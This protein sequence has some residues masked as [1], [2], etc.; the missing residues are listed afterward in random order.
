[1]DIINRIH[2]RRHRW[3]GAALLGLLTG[4]DFQR[5]HLSCTMG[6]WSRTPLLPQTLIKGK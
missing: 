2:R 1:M 4:I 6:L 5:E 3:L